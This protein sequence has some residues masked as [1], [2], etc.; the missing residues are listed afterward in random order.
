M[1]MYD[2]MHLRTIQITVRPRVREVS[3]ECRWRKLV[4]VQ[5]SQEQLRIAARAKWHT[6][7]VFSSTKKRGLA[8]TVE[9]RT[10]VDTL[11]RILA[12]PPGNNFQI[13]KDIVHLNAALN[14]TY[15]HM[16][17]PDFG[18]FL[19]T[20]YSD[21]HRLDKRKCAEDIACDLDRWGDLA[22][23]TPVLSCP[24]DY[25]DDLESGCSGA[26]VDPGEPCEG[27]NVNALDER[28]VTGNIRWY[29]LDVPDND[30]GGDERNNVHSPRYPA[31]NDWEPDD[32]A[33]TRGV[34]VWNHRDCANPDV[35][36][37]AV[38][39]DGLFIN[40][41]RMPMH[42]EHPPEYN[43]AA[44]FLNDAVRETLGSQHNR[45]CFFIVHASL[46]YAKSDVWRWREGLLL[47]ED[48]MR[49]LIVVGVL[50][51]RALH[52][53]RKVFAVFRYLDGEE[54]RECM[55]ELLNDFRAELRVLIRAW[56]AGHPNQR[57]ESRPIWDLWMR[58]QFTEMV[59]NAQERVSY[60]LDELESAWANEN[61]PLAARVRSESSDINRL[62]NQIANRIRFPLDGLEEAMPV[63]DA[64]DPIIQ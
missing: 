58:H 13:Q 41:R 32:E 50:P 16:V 52:E 21:F 49:P 15:P 20:N 35:R 12:A 54:V 24:V 56:N 10:F 63:D 26:G 4:S 1:N 46:N 47:H 61:T 40:G 19:E 8:T 31:A 43:T 42:S 53:I 36:R 55:I 44:T 37:V 38:P 39:L 33:R 6:S 17:F 22:S 2:L 64:N 30:G 25:C 3:I 51:W 48:E 62:R 28:A 57:W 14:E 18:D 60:W 5:E 59:R 7:D 29:C 34:I 9:A 23:E 27:T 11:E 45:K